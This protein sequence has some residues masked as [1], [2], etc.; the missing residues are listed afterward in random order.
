MKIQNNEELRRFEETIDA[1]RSAVW[2]ITPDGKQ[3]DLK[4]PMERY[5]GLGKR[6]HGSAMEEPEIYA[7]CREDEI[8][9]LRFIAASRVLSE[10]R[11]A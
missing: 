11:A 4:V 1:C 10:A 7:A 2:L 6:I 8:R 3:Y 9:L 5:R